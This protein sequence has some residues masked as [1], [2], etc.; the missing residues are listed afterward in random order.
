MKKWEITKSDYIVNDRWLKL[1]ADSCITTDGKTIEPYYVFE[2][3]DWVNCF[4][5]DEDLNV[6]ML[7]HYRHGVQK[8]LLELVSG[9]IEDSDAS[10]LAAVK[11]ELKEELGYIGGETYQT[12]VSYPNPANQTNKVFSFL[13]VGGKCSIKQQLE[14]GEDLV[15][16]PFNLKEIVTR[17]ENTQSTEIF[18]S[19][20]LASFFFALTLIKSSDLAELAS[21][22]AALQ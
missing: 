22:K 9:G 14:A 11:R 16:Q 21:L 17:L 19:M 13:A 2:Y 10:P 12:G 7:K 1:R 3:K 6:I 20:H 15:I 4:V 18:Q 8:E 5:I